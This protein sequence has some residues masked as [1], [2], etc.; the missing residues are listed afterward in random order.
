MKNVTPLHFVHVVRLIHLFE[1]KIGMKFNS[2]P[3]AKNIRKYSILQIGTLY[4][5]LSGISVNAMLFPVLSI[6]IRLIKY[7]KNEIAQF[8]VFYNDNMTTSEA[9]NVYYH[10]Y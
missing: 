6:D 4:I 1:Q 5:N 9:I 3:S 7:A 10:Y 8:S 2:F